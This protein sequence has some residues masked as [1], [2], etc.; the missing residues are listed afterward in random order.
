M[1]R[2]TL[3]T[4]T[5]SG[6]GR[7]AVKMFASK[8]WNVIATMRAPEKES[9]LNE[10]QNVIVTRLDVLDHD[11]IA[12]AIQ[13][14]IDR[15]GQID[16]LVNSAGYGQYGLFEAVSREQII[17]QY[18]TNVFG[19]MDVI[20]A[21]LPHFRA[22]NGGTII[23]ISSCGGLIGLPTMS[24]YSSSKFALEG[25]SEALSYE[26]ASQ[27]IY[28]KLVEPG[29]FQSNFHHVSAQMK[30][31]PGESEPYNTF[32]IHTGALFASLVGSRSTTS[33]DVAK[34]VYEAATDGKNQLRYIIAGNVES[35]VKARQELSDQ[36]FIDFMRSKLN[37]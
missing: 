14:G 17:S 8:G 30:A 28:V 10:L 3:I 16:T 20:R 26:L 7:E 2:T 23:N 35:L 4:G 12:T 5:S 32:L 21:I 37:Q 9:E 1:K 25:F 15:F 6:L 22:N 13:R 18:E 34:V 33:E 24:V 36:D 11:S 27:N 29:G 31:T 19:L